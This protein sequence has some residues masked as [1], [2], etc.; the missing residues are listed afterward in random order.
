MIATKLLAAVLVCSSHYAVYLHCRSD[1]GK[2]VD[3]PAVCVQ[4]GGTD[5]ILLA[6]LPLP[7][8]CEVIAVPADGQS[9][10][11]ASPRQ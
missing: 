9:T 3:T 5:F 2:V 4:D 8:T 6:N 10:A 11:Q 1:K 7:A